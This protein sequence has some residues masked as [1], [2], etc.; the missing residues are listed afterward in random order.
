M[1]LQAEVDSVRQEL[2]NTKSENEALQ[3]SSKSMDELVERLR[4]ENALLN[5]NSEK[6]LELEK[7]SSQLKVDISLFIDSINVVLYLKNFLK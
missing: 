6:A 3:D 4:E 1:K 5:S 7:A 2:N